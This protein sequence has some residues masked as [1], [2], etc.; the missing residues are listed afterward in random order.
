MTAEDFTALDLPAQ[1]AVIAAVTVR[2]GVEDLHADGAFDDDQAPTFNRLVRQEFFQAF[3]SVTTSDDPRHVDYLVGLAEDASDLVEDDDFRMLCLTGAAARAVASF[4]EIEQIGPSALSALTDA[5]QQS[6]LGLD[7]E[8][9]TL[10]NPLAV[11]FL[12]SYIADWEPPEFSSEYRR[13]L[14]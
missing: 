13:L 6:V 8:F 9:A 7:D 11:Q 12:L 4:G 14:D 1:H 2:N 10:A 5:A 3:S